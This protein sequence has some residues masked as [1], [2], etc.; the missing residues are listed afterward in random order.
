M[1]I[2][3]SAL[4]D[5]DEESLTEDLSTTA[6]QTTM[7]S[8][9]SGQNPIL[10]ITPRP[11]HIDT[12]C[13][14]HDGEI[15][16]LSAPLMMSPSSDGHFRRRASSKDKDDPVRVYRVS[17][18]VS[19]SQF[20]QRRKER[21]EECCHRIVEIQRNLW[22]NTIA[23]MN[24]MAKVLFWF[25]LIAM[26]A[27]IVYYTRELAINGYVVLFLER[28]LSFDTCVVCLLVITF[29]SNGCHSFMFIF[30]VT[31]IPH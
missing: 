29:F 17:S 8:S 5:I 3:E 12:S 19:P 1:M 15:E 2:N 20:Y 18:Q 24:L 30:I 6:N 21:M 26:S 10:K 23:F 25:S 11:L 27:G 16:D 14:L 9:S 7:I 22:R 31:M 13:D 4:P 28:I